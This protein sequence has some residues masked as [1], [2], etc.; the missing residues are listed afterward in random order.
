VDPGVGLEPG[1]ETPDDNLTLFDFQG[2][3]LPD[4]K[5]P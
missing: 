2:R 3:A 1:A 4:R 5:L